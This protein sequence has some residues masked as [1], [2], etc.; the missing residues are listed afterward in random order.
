[1]SLE[2]G[3]KMDEG[4]VMRRFNVLGT[5]EKCSIPWTVIAPHEG[6]A[7]CN[8]GQDLETL[9]RRGGLCWSEIIAVL[10]D[11][12]YIKMDEFIARKKV[13]DIVKKQICTVQMVQNDEGHML[14]MSVVS[15]ANMCLQMGFL[16]QWV[17]FAILKLFLLPITWIRL[18]SGWKN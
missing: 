1:M 14:M 2:E 3:D 15:G 8:H 13:E 4:K 10:E 11:R 9:N 6:Q 7:I 18:W 16:K 17:I 5:N 12:R